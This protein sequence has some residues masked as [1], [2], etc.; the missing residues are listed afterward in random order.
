MQLID[1]WNNKVL[2]KEKSAEQIDFCRRTYENA[3][4]KPHEKVIMVLPSSSQWIIQYLALEKIGAVIIPIDSDDKIQ[5]EEKIYLANASFIITSEEAGSE[6]IKNKYEYISN[7]SDSSINIY[8]C[9][10]TNT[11]VKNC[12]M[13]IYT[14]GT[15]GLPKLAMLSKQSVE[16]VVDYYVS[17]FNQYKFDNII[18]ALPLSAIYTI[19]ICL[20]AIKSR[21]CLIFANYK[22]QNI[23]S[24]ITQYNVNLFPAV[25]IVVEKMYSKITASIE[26]NN[27]LIR[28][29]INLLIAFCIQFRRYTNL[30]LGKILFKFIHNKTGN[31][32]KVILSGG[33][34]IPSHVLYKMYGLGYT[35]FEGYG[36]TET[37][38]VITVRK[39]EYE[40]IG[41]VGKPINDV[42]ITI[43]SDRDKNEICI[44]TNQL[45]SGYHDTTV[46]H[47][48]KEI[49]F[50]T[51]DTGS[52]REDGNLIIS[53]RLKNIIIL[54]DERKVNPEWLEELI[55][56]HT[57]IKNPVVIGY[58]NANS[59]GDSIIL[60]I[61]N[62]S[63]KNS[64]TI[65]TLE[66]IN[67][68][69]KQ[70][71]KFDRIICVENFP[72]NKLGKCCRREL[73]ILYAQES[74]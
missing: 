60:F 38:G 54:A 7:I 42:Q 41:T 40:T 73:K 6:I 62:D 12:H 5:L 64:R 55:E 35:I 13:M 67:N 29:A 49:P 32:L 26:N 19:A 53:G 69:F 9:K 22:N 18:I 50:R 30:N 20:A 27:F 48:Q 2:T 28:N 25:P 17:E 51:G 23:F 16:M 74:L 63:L 14:S 37:A 70:I 24:V 31:D 59:F 57:G 47:P 3:G 66:Y 21:K 43:G 39:G 36:L 58:N 44:K 34:K 65:P 10:H 71:C 1:S 11:P 52:I 46:Q 15:D 4:I 56:V 68:Q 72:R 45:F 61:E 33:A 8:R